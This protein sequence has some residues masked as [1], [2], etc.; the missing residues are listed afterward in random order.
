MI[1]NPFFPRLTR[2][3]RSHEADSFPRSYSAFSFLW[4][5][6]SYLQSCS[7]QTPERGD[8]RDDHQDD[9]RDGDHGD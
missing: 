4:A 9:D 1:R 5:S 3:I 6:S 7:P 2:A 8:E